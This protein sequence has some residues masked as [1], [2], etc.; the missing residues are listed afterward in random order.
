MR[1][2]RTDLN[3]AICNLGF[4]GAVLATAYVGVS[5]GKF[6]NMATFYRVFQC[7]CKADILL[8]SIYAFRNRCTDYSVLC[9]YEKVQLR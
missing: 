2:L 1:A 5:N 9:I 8:Y 6:N 3:K 4:I 7:A